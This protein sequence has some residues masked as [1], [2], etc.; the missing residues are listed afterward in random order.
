M[1]PNYELLELLE[2]NNADEREAMQG[3]YYL[4][5]AA[6][7]EL[8]ADR[9]TQDFHDRL[10]TKIEDYISEEMKH[11]RGLQLLAQEL[12]GINPEGD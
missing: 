8:K 5:D 11:S 4:L 3:Y 9:I 7:D 12:S 2:A 10:V 1:G 6:A